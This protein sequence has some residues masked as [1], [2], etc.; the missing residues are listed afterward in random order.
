MA[1]ETVHGVQHLLEMR[2]KAFAGGGVDKQS[3]ERAK[4]KLTAR[5]RIELLL[6]PDSRRYTPSPKLHRFRME[7]KHYPG[8][9]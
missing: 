9:G 7:D 8:D 1:N 3:A 5:E 6:D 2:Q 4:G